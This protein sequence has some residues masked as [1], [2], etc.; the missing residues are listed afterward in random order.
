MNT[1][2]LNLLVRLRIL[3]HLILYQR[4]WVNDI[5]IKVP[6]IGNIGLDNNPQHDLW[7]MSILRILLPQQSS[8]FIDVGVNLGQTLIKVKSLAPKIRYIG[9]EPNPSCALYVQRLIRLNGFVGCEVIPAALSNRHGLASLDFFYDTESDSTASIIKEFRPDQSISRTITV[10]VCSFDELRPFL[11]IEDLGIV[12]IDVEGAELEVIQSMQRTLSEQRPILIV[13]VLP[14]YSEEN[15]F[16]RVRQEQ[17]ERILA[18]NDYVMFRII[19]ESGN[20]LKSLQKLNSIGVHSSLNLCDY[21]FSPKEN[22]QNV[23]DSF[24]VV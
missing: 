1:H 2:L 3:K 10:S 19:K 5:S 4:I 18:A 13:E 6:L 16:R 15:V 21:L 8:S 7:L 17:I 14:V 23:V 20:G 22:E 12:K 24:Q 11:G 9:F